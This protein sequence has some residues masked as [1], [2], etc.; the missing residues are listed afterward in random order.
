L[1]CSVVDLRDVV[2]LDTPV[3]LHGACQPKLYLAGGLVWVGKRLAATRRRAEILG[4]LLGPELGVPV[5]RVGLCDDMPESVFSEWVETPGHWDLASA[6]VA[7]NYDALGA[8]LALDAV[9]GNADRNPRNILIQPLE[10]QDKTHMCTL[11]F[12]DH[13][14]AEAGDLRRLRGMGTSAHPGRLPGDYPTDFAVERACEA[15]AAL[16]V[17]IPESRVR[18]LV[19]ASCGTESPAIQNNFVE[20][21]AERLGAAPGIAEAYFRKVVAR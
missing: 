8:G 9:I 12:I 13:E 21:L 19:A 18:A 14:A 6:G 7:D 3:K 5:P 10:K 17:E 15:A 1:D 4:S 2:E 11:R 16:A 20:A